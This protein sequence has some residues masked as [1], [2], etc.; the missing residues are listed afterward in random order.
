MFEP[1]QMNV[2][3]HCGAPR[4]EMQ[5]DAD[6]R[7]TTERFQRR[8]VNYQTPHA[9]ASVEISGLSARNVAHATHAR[10]RRSPKRERLQHYVDESRRVKDRK[11]QVL[12]RLVEWVPDKKFS[13]L[14]PEAYIPAGYVL[15]TDVNREPKPLA[16]PKNWSVTFLYKLEA[17]ITAAKGDR[18]RFLRKMRKAVEP[19]YCTRG[20]PEE[21]LVQD[22]NKVIEWLT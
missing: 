22:L 9:D 7:M 21:L 20:G 11:N 1:I 18:A 19:R 17:V 15:R 3:L 12:A 14:M 16:H 10:Q 4:A 13:K 5:C 8:R 6:P 2:Q